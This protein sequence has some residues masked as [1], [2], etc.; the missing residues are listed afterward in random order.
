VPKNTNVAMELEKALVSCLQ[1]LEDLS[2]PNKFD[3][4]ENLRKNYESCGDCCSD[5]QKLKKM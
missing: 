3:S 4:V 2:D 5:I 1:I